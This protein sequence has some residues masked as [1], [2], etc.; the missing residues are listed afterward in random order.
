MNLFLHN[1]F[2]IHNIAFFICSQELKKQ[3]EVKIRL[4]YVFFCTLLQIFLGTGI[5]M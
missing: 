5:T 1:V 3:N 2:L 4:S